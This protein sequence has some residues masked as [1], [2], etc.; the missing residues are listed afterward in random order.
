MSA[1]VTVPA[2]HVMPNTDR[3]ERAGEKMPQRI[4]YR[5]PQTRPARI[6]PLNDS[7][8]NTYGTRIAR[9]RT[10]AASDHATVEPW[11][12]G[13]DQREHTRIQ[14]HAKSQNPTMQYKRQRGEISSSV[15]SDMTRY[16]PQ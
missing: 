15:A 7:A 8:A 12:R 2:T 16:V 1:A 5:T 13:R 3:S 11:S 10:S 14:N 4:G 9:R 6:Q